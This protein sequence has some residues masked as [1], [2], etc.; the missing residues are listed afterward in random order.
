MD[1]KQWP[2]KRDVVICRLRRITANAGASSG[3]KLPYRALCGSICH[4][5]AQM[6]SPRRVG[7]CYK[8]GLLLY[9]PEAIGPN[10]R[11]RTIITRFLKPRHSHLL[12]ATTTCK[13]ATLP[14]SYHLRLMRSRFP[15]SDHAAKALE[16]VWRRAIHKGEG[17]NIVDAKSKAKSNGDF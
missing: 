11:S 15:C 3:T 8:P 10:T 9:R 4:M 12:P 2:E 13:T 6:T 17:E 1:R 14:S 5:Y 16:V 7:S